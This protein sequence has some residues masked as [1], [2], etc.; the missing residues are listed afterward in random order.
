MIQFKY[1]D[2]MN[3]YDVKVPSSLADKQSMTTIASISEDA[4]AEI[5]LHRNLPIKLLRQVLLHWEEYEH[6]LAKELEDVL[7]TEPKNYKGEK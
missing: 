1:N 7:H 5:T 2:I 4:E 6:Q 3:R